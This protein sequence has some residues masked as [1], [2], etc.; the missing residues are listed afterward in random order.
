V[1]NRPRLPIYLEFFGSRDTGN[2]LTQRREGA[3]NEENEEENDEDYEGENE[4]DYDD[5]DNE[6][7][8]D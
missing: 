6:E 1:T 8:L 3:K 4:E 5:E 7:S 2:D